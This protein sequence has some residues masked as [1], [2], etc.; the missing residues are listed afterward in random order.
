MRSFSRRDFLQSAAVF[1][2]A[3]PLL[4]AIEPFVRA[5]SPHFRLGLAAYSFRD[6]FK[7]SSVKQQPVNGDRKLTMEGFID[8]CADWGVDGAELT[9]YYFPKDVTN[10]QLA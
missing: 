3:T 5:G 8:L 10:E 4:R 7:D 2:A 6:S 9:S 1:C